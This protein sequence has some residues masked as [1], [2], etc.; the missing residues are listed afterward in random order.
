MW[1][2]A[3]D[4]ESVPLRA[5][6]VRG[7]MAHAGRVKVWIAVEDP[8]GTKPVPSPL[9]KAGSFDLWKPIPFGT[10]KRGRLVS[11]QLVWTSV[12][13]GAIPR[14]GKTFAVRLIVAAAALDPRVRLMVWD[15]MPGKDHKA[16]SAMAHRYGCGVR[17]AVVDGLVASLRE[18][19]VDMDR[20]FE[21]LAGLSDKECPDGKVTPAIC[22]RKDLDMPLTVIVIDEVQRYLEH[23]EGRQSTVSVLPW[24][25]QY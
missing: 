25:R 24:R 21:K 13:I 22:A 2:L 15:G 7:N 8:C 11:L 1:A 19:V 16:A 23:P 17:D 20:R 18:A 5:D 10:D 4:R 6:G 12:L 14:M 9:A 3:V